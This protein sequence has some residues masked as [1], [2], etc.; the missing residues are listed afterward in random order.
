MRKVGTPGHR[1]GPLVL[2]ALLVV[3][4]GGCDG[5]DSGS[6]PSGARDRAA[7]AATHLPAEAAGGACQLLNFDSV[8]AATGLSFA[9]AASSGAGST[10]SCV[11]QTEGA[12]YPDLRLTTTGTSA[13]ETVFKTAVQPRGAAALSGLGKVAYSATSGP[14]AQAGS[15]PTAEICWL[16]HNGRLLRLRAT[17]G[18]DAQPNAASAIVPKLAAMAKSIEAATS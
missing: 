18:A 6:A 16:S 10:F 4:S 3:L 14:D 7:A 13:D 12:R 5:R 15:G 9:V 11:L 8:R 2:S 17:L 1:P